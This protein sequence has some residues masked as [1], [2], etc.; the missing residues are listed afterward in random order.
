MAYHVNER[1]HQYEPADETPVRDLS[2]QFSPY[3]HTSYD[4]A[5]VNRIHLNDQ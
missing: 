1:R 5:K 2:P 4:N 3:L